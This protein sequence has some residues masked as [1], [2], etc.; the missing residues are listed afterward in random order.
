VNPIKNISASATVN[1][2]ALRTP[3][4]EGHSYHLYQTDDADLCV[5]RRNQKRSI[6]G[7]Q[8]KK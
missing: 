7:A 5:Q 2:H 4:R 3:V 8:F 6:G 1:N